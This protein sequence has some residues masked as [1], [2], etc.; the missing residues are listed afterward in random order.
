M[1]IY[2]GASQVVL[3]VKNLPANAGNVRDAGSIP[4]G[5]D[6]LDESMWIHS[7]ILSWRIPWTEEPG[8]LQSAGPQR[9]RHSW[10][11][12]AHT[13]TCICYYIFLLCIMFLPFCIFLGI[14]EGLYFCSSGYLDIIIYNAL[15]FVPLLLG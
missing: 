10:S 3:V 13:H 7:S 8:A 15:I 14:L 4:S 6:P 2:Y 1:Y 5:E 9:V 11:D 12:W